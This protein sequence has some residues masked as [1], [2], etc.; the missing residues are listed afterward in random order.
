MHPP[1]FPLLYRT[2]STTPLFHDSPCLLLLV[3][4]GPLTRSSDATGR[5]R[6]VHLGVIDRIAD[7]LRAVGATA[8]ALGKHKTSW[9]QQQLQQQQ[10]NNTTTSPPPPPPLFDILTSKLAL[11]A[12]QL[13]VVVRNTALDSSGR[14]AVLSSKTVCLLCSLLRPFR[15][16]PDLVLNCL[17][18]TAKL[19]LQEPFRSQINS[20]SNHIRCLVEVLVLEG[21]HCQHVMNGDDEGDLE[22]SPPSSYTHS[23]PPF[24]SGGNGT[25]TSA[26]AR[27]S[28]NNDNSQLAKKWP[29]WYTWP[30]L[31]RVAF[32]LG[33]LTT[34]NGANRALIG[35]D[36]KALSPLLSLL[37]VL[38]S[39]PFP[40][41]PF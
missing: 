38:E 31:S 26:R 18:V 13:V 32:T 20:K 36:C 9:Q 11:I 4:L 12:A 17:R 10:G 3:L 7:T 2:N 5:R 37:Q 34:S 22:Q 39:P 6:L 16:Y 35:V 27:E 19:S 23:D 28:N 25:S 8:I 14:A 1:P 15:G 41:P 33:N 24:S 40:L 30:L 29:F 21:T